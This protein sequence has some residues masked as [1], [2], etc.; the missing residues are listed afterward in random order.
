MSYNGNVMPLRKK[1]AY[2]YL[3]FRAVKE[4]GVQGK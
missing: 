2:G 4:P 3:G 1:V